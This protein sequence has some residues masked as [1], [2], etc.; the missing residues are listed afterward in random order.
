M[1]GADNIPERILNLGIGMQPWPS[2][3]VVRRERTEIGPYA[4]GNPIGYLFGTGNV[5]V[6]PVWS[7]GPHNRQICANS[8]LKRMFVEVDRRHS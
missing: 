2:D 6:Q 8:G 5:Q 7:I 1:V 4:G 3:Q